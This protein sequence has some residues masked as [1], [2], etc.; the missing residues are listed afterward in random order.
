M[1]VVHIISSFG[2]GGAELLIKDLA[3]NTR[4]DILVEVWAVGES[5]SGEFEER[6]KKELFLNNVAY[7]NIGKK[8]GRGRLDVVARIRKLVRI[9]RPD[10]INTHSE[11]ATFYTSLAIIGTGI[12]LVQTVHNT[13]I[14]YPFLQ[15]I[16][17]RVMTDKFVAISERCKSI[18]ESSIGPSHKKIRLIYNGVN[19]KKFQC[20]DREISQE[21]RNLLV[22]GRLAVQ[23][24]HHT[25][26]RAFAILKSRLSQ[27]GIMVP[28]LNIVGTGALKDELMKLSQDLGLEDFVKFLGARSD[29]PEILRQCDIWVMS[30][31][32]EGL[33]ISM[34]EAMASG[35]PIVATDVGSNSE[36]IENNINGSLVEKEN[37]EM[38]AQA[39]Y[40]LITDRERRR[41]YSE[42]A[43]LKVL[44]FSLQACLSSYTDLYLSLIRKNAG[45][46]PVGGI[47]KVS[48]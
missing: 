5:E 11:L 41:L 10:L 48:A 29:I 6:Y 2:P 36:V 22:I 38:L 47:K 37:P 19:V 46:I 4:K 27:E 40:R 16:L 8:A 7:A 42:N 9:R 33:S 26:L 21:V 17:A 34:L 25:L 14:H 45:F 28:V 32:W 13:V 43:R 35:I 31:R 20:S 30:S 44:D 18:I 12:K 15:R 1:K 3:I 39:I 24:D 23:K